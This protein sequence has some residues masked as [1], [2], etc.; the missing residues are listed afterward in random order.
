M[1]G[2]IRR[3]TVIIVSAFQRH[4]LLLFEMQPGC[5]NVLRNVLSLNQFSVLVTAGN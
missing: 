5:E 4:V 3:Q 2:L 1:T